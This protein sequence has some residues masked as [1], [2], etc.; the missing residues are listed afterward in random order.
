MPLYW[1]VPPLAARPKPLGVSQETV[2]NGSA[3]Q[4]ATSTSAVG[5]SHRPAART[6]GLATPDSV[7]TAWSSR[8]SPTHS[9]RC[10]GSSARRGGR[11]DPRHQQGD[12]VA[13]PVPLAVRVA[14][15]RLQ[16]A[17]QRQ[18]ELGDLTRVLDVQ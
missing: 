18:R 5:L 17:G 7:E 13:Q 16:P 14:L 2:T 8:K 10:A 4:I 9:H 1:V 3:K 11:G 15:V 12:P 6:T